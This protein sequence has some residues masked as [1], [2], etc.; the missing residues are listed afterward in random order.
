MKYTGKLDINI[1]SQASTDVDRREAMIFSQKEMKGVVL[2][3]RTCPVNSVYS[4]KN[5]RH[6]TRLNIEKVKRPSVVEGNE[7]RSLRGKV[8]DRKTKQERRKVKW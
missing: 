8:K 2:L 6:G 5:C 4:F 7:L 3:S 1:I